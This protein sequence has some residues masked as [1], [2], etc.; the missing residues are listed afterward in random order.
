MIFG[1]NLQISNAIWP[2]KGFKDADFR[3]V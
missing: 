3:L 2:L 1:H